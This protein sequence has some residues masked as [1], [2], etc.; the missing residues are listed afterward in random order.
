MYVLNVCIPLYADKYAEVCARRTE[1]SIFSAATANEF[2][3][4]LLP[5][6]QS[7]AN[8]C[9]ACKANLPLQS[10]LLQATNVFALYI[11]QEEAYLMFRRRAAAQELATLKPI[12][13]VL[14]D[15]FGG[16]PAGVT[17]AGPPKEDAH[18]ESE[19]EVFDRLTAASRETHTKSVLDA[20]T[21]GTS[22]SVCN[23]CTFFV[24]HI[25]ITINYHF[26]MRLSYVI[27]LYFF[28]FFHLVYTKHA[29]C[30]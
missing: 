26:T 8:V 16:S 2:L 11:L 25:R 29:V 9:F 4:R 24:Y 23:V 22:L 15:L 19:Q 20:I 7:N 21:V 17:A 13:K 18:A 10:A 1:G 3:T 12:A 30:A 5:L 14:T 6:F 28:I 27:F